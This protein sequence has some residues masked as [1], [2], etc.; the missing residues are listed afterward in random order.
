MR[1]AARGEGPFAERLRGVL[2]AKVRHFARV[3]KDGEHGRELVHCR[4][5]AVQEAQAA[6][7]AEEEALLIELLAAGAA[8]GELSVADPVRTARALVHVYRSFSPPWLYELSDPM[9]L[10]LLEATHEIVLAG[11]QSRRR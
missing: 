7:L 5:R 1:G 8:A 9:A 6:F 10:E 11:L 3:G 2:D 4:A